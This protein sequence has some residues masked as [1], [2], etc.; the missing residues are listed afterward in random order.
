M[1]EHTVNGLLAMEKSLRSRQQQLNSLANQSGST[2]VWGM[3]TEQEKR[4][5]PLYDIK[6]IDKKVVQIDKALF[7]IDQKVKESN[8]KT[9][10]EIDVDYDELV[11][12]IE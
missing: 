4:E 6:T 1:A 10:V 9:N 11:S 2:T 7:M 8:A 5:E 12:E 3:G